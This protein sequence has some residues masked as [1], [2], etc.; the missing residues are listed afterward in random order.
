MDK[1]ETKPLEKEGKISI[2]LSNLWLISGKYRFDFV[3]KNNKMQDI[4]PILKKNIEI[5]SKN[6]RPGI[7]PAYVDWVI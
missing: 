4:S 1:I 3:I 6:S 2:V 7:I 5:T